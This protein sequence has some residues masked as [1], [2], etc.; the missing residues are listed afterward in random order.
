MFESFRSVTIERQSSR[1]IAFA[2]PVR[3]STSLF[4]LPPLSN[5]TQTCFNF[6]TFCSACPLTCSVHCLEC[7]ER[8]YI[9]HRLFQ[10]WH[11]LV[12]GCTQLQTVE[13]AGWRI[14]TEDASTSITKSSAKSKRLILQLP[15]VTPSLTRLCNS[16]R[17]MT[18]SGHNTQIYWSRTNTV[19]D[20]YVTPWTDTN[21]SAGIQWL[22]GPEK[23]DNNTVLQWHSPKFFWTDPDSCILEIAKTHIDIFDML[24]RLLED[25]L[26]SETFVCSA[27]AGTQAAPGII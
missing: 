22:N 25:L 17:H 7:L 6:F 3:V 10:C 2:L 15:V 18:R 27:T 24:P 19:N 13:S 26:K 21:V 16:Y 5:T 8:N 1:R 11:S 14:C 23:A 20:F 12:L 9:T 4:R